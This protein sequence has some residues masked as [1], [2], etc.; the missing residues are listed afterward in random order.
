M[1]R[2]GKVV[3]DRELCGEY[4]GPGRRLYPGLK[5]K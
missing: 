5:A 4:D 3:I 2:K 1:A